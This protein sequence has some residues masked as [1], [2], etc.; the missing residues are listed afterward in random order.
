[1]RLPVL[2]VSIMV[3]VVVDGGRPSTA[4]SSRQSSLHDSQLTSTISATIVQP[5]RF[6]ISTYRYSVLVSGTELHEILKLSSPTPVPDRH[7]SYIANKHQQSDGKRINIKRA[8]NDSREQATG[9]AEEVSIGQ[10]DTVTRE[11]NGWP[12]AEAG[13]EQRPGS[14]ENCFET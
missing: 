12:K 5:T 10:T 13:I 2:L 4:H 11:P 8:G 14:P 7:V 9:A 3:T 1:M 6:Q